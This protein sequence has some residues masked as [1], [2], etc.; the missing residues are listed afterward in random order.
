M[1]APLVSGT[2]RGIGGGWQA[3]PLGSV[4][5]GGGGE[6][7]LARLGF[8]P[9]GRLWRGRRR[10]RTVASDGNRRREA[11]ADGAKTAAAAEAAARAALAA[12]LRGGLRGKGRERKR[13]R[14]ILT[15]GLGRREGGAT[16]NGN[17]ERREDDGDGLRVALREGKR[18][19][20]GREGV[21]GERKPWPKAAAMVEAHRSREKRAR[22]TDLA[23]R[24]AD[25]TAQ[26]MADAAA[27]MA[28]CGGDPS[29][30]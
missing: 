23:E 21:Y 11:A 24:T 28:G 2:K 25:A 10:A 1:R 13:G 12:A 8:K 20:R 5:K 3:G 29:G 4:T 15:E 17:D 7:G 6:G 27:P 16:A 22:T 14:P 30:C 19:I 9:A 26:G 18:E